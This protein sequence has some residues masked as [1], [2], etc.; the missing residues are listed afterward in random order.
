MV[1]VLNVPADGA[2][3]ALNLEGNVIGNHPVK[4]IPSKTPIVPVNPIF[5][6]R[7]SIFNLN[8][9]FFIIL[10]DAFLD[11]KLMFNTV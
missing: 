11:S 10:L 9:F 7:V 6:P 2:K 8:K 1:I 4:V 3:Q 5:L